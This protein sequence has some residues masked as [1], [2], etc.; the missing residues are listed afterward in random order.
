ADDAATQIAIDGSGNAYITGYT[1]SATFPVVNAVAG[2]TTFGGI[3]DAFVTELNAAGNDLVYSEYLGGT[4][5]DLGNG[6]GIDTLGNIYVV[7]FTSS[8]DFPTV[9]PVQA[10]NAG[11]AHDAFVAKLTGASFT[12]A[13]YLGGTLDDA[14]MAVAA[15]SSGN[16][17]VVG[18]TTS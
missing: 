15:D 17:Y 12:Y 18:T 1:A 7:G 4:G 11:G 2:H 13:T 16:A 3:E 14:A 10:S 8:T 5:D 9:S 6:I